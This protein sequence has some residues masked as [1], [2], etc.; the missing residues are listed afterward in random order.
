MT[1]LLL[2]GAKDGEL[3]NP[4]ILDREIFLKRWFATYTFLSYE[5][6]CFL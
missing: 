1:L 5:D 3:F 4:K 6:A 2:A